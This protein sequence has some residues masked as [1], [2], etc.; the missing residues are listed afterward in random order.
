MIRKINLKNIYSIFVGALTY[1]Y[2]F[3]SNFLL[4]KTSFFFQND[5]PTL[6][7]GYLAYI[8]DNWR[9]PLTVTQN[10]FPGE[11]FSIVWMDSIPLFSFILKLFYS[12]TGFKVFNP[13]PM[14]YLICYILFAYF[15]GKIL[16]L[17]IKNDLLYLLS[18]ILLINT[19]LMINR[20]YWHSSLSAH[21]LILSG[22]YCYL[23]NKEGDFKSLNSFAFLTGVSI[24]IHPYIFTMVLTIFIITVLLATY[25][26]KKLEVRNSIFVLSSILIFY[27][28]IFYSKS[29]DGQFLATDYFKYGAEFNSFFCGEYPIEIINRYLWCSPPYTTYTLEGYAYLGVGFITLSFILLI[30]PL[31]TIQSIKKHWV[32][33]LGLIFMLLYAFGNKWKLAHFQFFEFQPTYLHMKLLEIFRA[34]GRYSWPIYYFFIFLIIFKIY[35]IKNF[36]LIL[37]FLGVGLFLQLT[38]IYSI[39]ESKSYDFQENILTI[40]QVNLGEE[41]YNNLPNDIL[42]LLPDERCAWG[43]IDHYIVGLSYL[44]QG[45]TIQSSRTARLKIKGEYCLNYKVT[46][47]LISIEPKHFLINDKNLISDNSFLESYLCVNINKY[48]SN[49]LEPAYCKLAG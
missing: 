35:K 1:L 10:I 25:E 24:Y 22:I 39:Y 27:F 28:L 29:T 32:L 46:D 21:W 13:F 17:R 16:Q 20:M 44:N 5:H 33:N 37:S 3:G 48:T 42:Y 7:A 11:N 38:D 2:I 43:E 4:S 49:N 8:N 6:H 18:L 41:I 26:R 40:Q 12:L 30:K 47:D 34:T 31:E 19:P 15:A 9:F 14:W 23:I 36:Y 45:G